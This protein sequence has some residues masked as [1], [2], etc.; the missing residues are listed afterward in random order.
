MGNNRGGG[1][2]GGGEA[3]V[4]ATVDFPAFDHATAD[5][6]EG[7]VVF[8]RGENSIVIVEGIYTL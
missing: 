8:T 3:A 5:P 7:A 4:P 2:G 1:G 6:E